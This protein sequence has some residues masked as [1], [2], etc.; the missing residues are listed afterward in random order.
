MK[1]KS[2][3]LKNLKQIL[4]QEEQINSMGSGWNRQRIE[5]PRIEVSTFQTL[6][7]KKT[8]IAAVTKIEEYI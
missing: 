6:T 2:S 1:K 8:L 4:K 5:L 7:A 3:H